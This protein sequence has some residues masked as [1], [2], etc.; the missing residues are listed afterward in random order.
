MGN[1]IEV[2]REGQRGRRRRRR[3]RSKELRMK[4]TFGRRG[5]VQHTFTQD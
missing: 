4:H 3:R 5:E 1:W 2:N